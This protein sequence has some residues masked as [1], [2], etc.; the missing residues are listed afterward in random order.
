MLKIEN[1]GLGKKEGFRYVCALL[2]AVAVALYFPN[3]DNSSEEIK[4]T[5]IT[6]FGNVYGLIAERNSLSEEAVFSEE[7]VNFANK[8]K[9]TVG[10]KA[11]VAN[12]PFDGS[13]LSSG[14]VGLNVA[15][16][17]LETAGY[18]DGTTDPEGTL[19]RANLCN[20]MSDS[21]T[22][23]ALE[24]SGIRYVILFDIYDKDGERM[25]DAAKDLSLWR[26]IMNVSDDTP[27]FEIVLAEGDMRLYRLTGF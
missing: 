9:A 26:G 23:D 21:A 22:Y 16:R 7:E 11:L 13:Y 4:E 18:W 20:Y 3:Y 1:T 2:V 14:V 19:I 10:E 25:Y 5:V 8:A 17:A 6:P 12:I 15:Y 24:N 27:G